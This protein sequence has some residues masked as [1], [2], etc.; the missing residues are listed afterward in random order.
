MILDYAEFT[1]LVREFADELPK[2]LAGHDKTR[3]FAP[4]IQRLLAFA[5]TRFT[6]AVVGQMRSG[7]SSLLNALIGADL[8]VVGVNETTATIN[9]F[10]FGEGE[11]TRRFRIHWRGRPPEDRP[12]KDVRDI[13]EWVGDSEFAKETRRLEFFANT[14]FLKTA[15]VVDTP[16]TRSLVDDHTRAIN[17]FLANRAQAE[18]KEAGGGA[19]AILYV[20]QAV[21]RQSDT[22]MLA[23][24]KSNTR[25]P[26]S[27]PHNSLA[28]VHKWET[29]EAD[30]PHAEAQ[31]KTERIFQAMRDFVC[32]AMPV[33][34]PLAKAAESYPDAFWNSTLDLAANT[35][36]SDLA[37]LLLDERDFR[38]EACA[39]CPLDASARNQLR[40]DYST[41]PWPSL[42]VILR[43]AQRRV[44]GNPADL[45]SHVLEVS[46]LPKLR[47]E[48]RKRFF[49]RTEVLKMAKVLAAAWDPCQRTQQI[50]RN[51]KAELI[52]NLN[53]AEHA[54]AVLT[55]RVKR[56]AELRSALD[57]IQAGAGAMESELPRIA[58]NLQS[59]GQI[60]TPV[61]DTQLEM[62]RDL[63]MLD[64]LDQ[65]PTAVD[66]TTME[67]L[68]CLFG[69]RNGAD[70]VARLAS[71]G[72]TGKSGVTVDDLVTAIGEL[73]SLHRKSTSPFIQ[74]LDH[75]VNRLGAIADWMETKSLR[76]IPLT[77]RSQQP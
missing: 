26:D 12:F 50:L 74:A 57:F 23:E 31:A 60:V 16:G 13:R 32:G 24:F 15:D 63:A 77:N 21:A 4:Q 27:P 34:A 73:R 37:D 62:E 17:E 76:E 11:E 36:A 51:H 29:L 71:F 56:D 59:I 58:E 38:T 70:I 20:V 25:L 6:L 53:R 55:D 7:K 19:D 67:Q 3:D 43:L 14:E 52:D 42:K 22:E 8:A 44:A 41:L 45:R 61:R 35:P 72:A 30:D 40:A 68:R 49:E 28:V 54:R 39:R 66:A 9:H 75:A 2:I 47:H 64:I 33:S 10:T 69:G 46:G 1:K 5:E 48:I 18:S 65:C